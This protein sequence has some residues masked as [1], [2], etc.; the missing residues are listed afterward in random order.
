MEFKEWLEL[1]ESSGATRERGLAYPPS[2]DAY[3]SR[4]SQPDALNFLKFKF[5]P[6]NMRRGKRKTIN[7]DKEDLMKIPFVA[8]RS[9]QLP[10]EE[11]GWRH[12]PDENN[13]VIDTEE[14]KKLYRIYVK[15]RSMP[16]GE[17]LG[18]WW[19]HKPDDDSHGAVEVVVD[20]DE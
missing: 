2:A 13:K 8:L 19:N 18:G 14:L 16:S 10:K 11:G 3:G 4:S 15:S 7:I 6:I 5:S 9:L 12:Q 20:E 17:Y 1:N